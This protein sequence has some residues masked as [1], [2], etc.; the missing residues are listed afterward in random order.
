MPANARAFQVLY[1]QLEIFDRQANIARILSITVPTLKII[2]AIT[3]VTAGLLRKR[4]RV[5][6][7]TAAYYE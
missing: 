4:A 3:G 6:P 2:A 5:L 1:R 7:I